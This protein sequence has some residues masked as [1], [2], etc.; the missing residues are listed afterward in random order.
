MYG[1][2]TISNYMKHSLDPKLMNSFLSPWKTI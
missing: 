2:D 1:S